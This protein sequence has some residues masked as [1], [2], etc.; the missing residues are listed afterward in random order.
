MLKF[1]KMQAAS[2]SF[3][4]GFNGFWA[5]AFKVEYQFIGSFW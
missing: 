5:N 1:A 3:A 2:E 4:L